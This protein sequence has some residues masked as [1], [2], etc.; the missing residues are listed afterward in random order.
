V[1]DFDRDTVAE[2]LGDGR[3]RVRFDPRWHVARGPNG[4]YVAAGLVRAIRAEVGEGRP[5]R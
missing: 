5:L 4:G 3:Y 2:P 1:T